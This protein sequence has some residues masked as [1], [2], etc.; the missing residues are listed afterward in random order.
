LYIG[1]YSIATLPP[2]LLSGVLAHELGHLLPG[3]QRLLRFE[4]ATTLLIPTFLVA[5]G[6]ILGPQGLTVGLLIGAY[7][8]GELTALALGRHSETVSDET[9]VRLG[10]GRQFRAY[11]D[12]ARAEMGELEPDLTW[13]RSH[14]G[15]S[16]RIAHLERLMRMSKIPAEPEPQAP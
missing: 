14:P 2:E 15:M 11:L 16:A 13:L 8:L 1:H 4:Q 10:L 5:L 7:C 3:Q 6:L 9:A 12:Y